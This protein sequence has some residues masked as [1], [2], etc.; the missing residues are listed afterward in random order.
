MLI[1]RLS[2]DFLCSND[3]D[4][5]SPETPN[6]YRIYQIATICTNY[7]YYTSFVFMEEGQVIDPFDFSRFNNFIMHRLV[8][9]DSYLNSIVIPPKT[10]RSDT[11]FFFRKQVTQ[12]DDILIDDFLSFIDYSRLYDFIAPH[13][14]SRLIIDAYYDWEKNIKT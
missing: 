4:F 7:P 5:L 1:T 11:N 13:C 8:S 6:D 14:D 10:A 9:D 2:I 12:Y 3:V